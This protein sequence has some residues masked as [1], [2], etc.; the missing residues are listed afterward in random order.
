[1]ESTIKRAILP[2]PVI[3]QSEGLYEY[4]LDTAAYPREAEPLKELRKATASHP[5]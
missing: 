3:L 2:N 5:M 1:M 4:I